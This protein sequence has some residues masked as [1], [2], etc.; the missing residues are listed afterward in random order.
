[1]AETPTCP[2][3]GDS[4]QRYA[5]LEEENR[6]RL[7][8]CRLTRGASASRS[9]RA[10]VYEIKRGQWQSP[11][12]R[13]VELVYRADTNDWNVISSVMAP[14]DEYGLAGLPELEG[15]ALDLGAHIG[16]V[17]V[18][19]L[20]D[21]PNL[22]VVAVEPVPANV[23]L[24]E[25]NVYRNG[26]IDRIAPF[27]AAIGPPD[28]ATTVVR[29]GYRGTE[30]AEHHAFVGNS[31]LVYPEG[32]EL[33]YEAIEVE[34]LNL[35]WF[36]RGRAWGPSGLTFTKLDT[37]GG[38][39]DFLA[40]GDPRI[41]GRIHGEWHPTGGHVQADLVAL[42]DATHELTFSG[43]VAGPGGFVAVPR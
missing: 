28:V 15:W 40:G 10:H 29:F 42:L 16:A 12:G 23:E 1:M 41:L 21:H 2:K 35:E 39:W 26:W 38:E 14:H 30:L 13:S 19:L 34:V 17:T 25:Q 6:L 9:R 20:A 22:E 5:Y 18:A 32:G 24:L 7:T 3:C 43:P 33:Q 36:S 31:M 4:A 11:R 27:T 8:C 37:E